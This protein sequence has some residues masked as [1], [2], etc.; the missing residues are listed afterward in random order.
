MPFTLSTAGDLTSIAGS[1]GALNGDL[2]SVQDTSNFSTAICQL[3]GAWVGTVSFQGSVEDVP[4]NYTNLTAINVTTGAVGGSFTTNGLYA[5]PL[6]CKWFRIRVTAYTSGT[7]IGNTVFSLDDIPFIEAGNQVVSGT[8]ALSAGAASIGTVGLN[9]GAAS[10]GTVGLNAGTALVGFTSGGAV[11][12]AGNALTAGRLTSASTATGF[13]K[14]SA[15]RVYNWSLLNTNAAARYLHLYAKAT[16]PTL[17]TDTPVITIP[18]PASGQVSLSSDIGVSLA[19]GVA[20]AVTTDNVAI[21]ATTGAAGDVVGT[22]Y[23]L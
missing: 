10:I 7:V 14:A 18:L 5:I 17:G 16:A 3:T 12:T 4:A 22:V 21:P 13:L 19:T 6:T 8:V 1:V 2:V 15:G 11:S 20:Y 9:A 23:Y